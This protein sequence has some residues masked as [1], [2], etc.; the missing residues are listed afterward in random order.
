MK[1]GGSKPGG[2]NPNNPSSEVKGA[3]NDKFAAAAQR[4]GGTPAA[5]GPGSTEAAGQVSAAME[6]LRATV[7]S[8]PQDTDAAAQKIVEGLL[9]GQYGADAANDPGFAKLAEAVAERVKG[10]PQ[11]SEALEKVIAGLAQP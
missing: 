11:L 8:V 4:A 9:K 3:S 2:V 6:K 10:D 5:G 1:V 7:G